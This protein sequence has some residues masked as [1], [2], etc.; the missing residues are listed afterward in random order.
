MSVVVAKPDPIE[1]DRYLVHCPKCNSRTIGR[2][3]TRT[4]DDAANYPWIYFWY[5]AVE[6][7]VCSEVMI[8][9]QSKD[10]G[11]YERKIPRMLWPRTSEEM[12]MTIPETLRRE[13]GEAQACFRGASYTATVVMVRR[14]LEGLCVEH[15]LKSYPLFKALGQMKE[16]G[17]IDGRLLEWA[18]ALRSLGNEGAHFTG[19]AVSREDAQDSLTFAEAILNYMYVFSEQFAEFKKRRDSPESEGAASDPDE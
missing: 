7:E 13:V 18:Q 19:N 3:I 4:I 16:Q 2:A 14:T 5:A 8:V 17:L 6:C 12:S 10:I 1:P 11:P 9:Q 15:G